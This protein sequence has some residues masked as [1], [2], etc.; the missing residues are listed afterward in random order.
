L[1]AKELSFFATTKSPQQYEMAI[2]R[3][4]VARRIGEAGS[5]CE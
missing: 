3:A 4:G 5:R 1:I 2:V